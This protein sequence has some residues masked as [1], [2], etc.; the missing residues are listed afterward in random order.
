MTLIPANF[1]KTPFLHLRVCG[2]K[3]ATLNIFP[4]RQA[5]QSYILRSVFSDNIGN[6]YPHTRKLPEEAIPA[7]HPD[8]LKNT[9]FT[10]AGVRV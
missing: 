7:D 5:A 4:Q 9:R 10:F 8:F 6:I 2:Y 3:F 1:Q